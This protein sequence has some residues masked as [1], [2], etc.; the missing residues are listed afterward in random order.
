MKRDT[1]LLPLRLPC[2]TDK[3]A[4]QLVELLQQLIA[5]FEHHYGAQIHR[6]HRQQ[7]DLHQA[8]K[9]QPSSPNDPPF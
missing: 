9:S 7:R 5:A 8:R 3:S 2:L 4:A 6:Y 1:V